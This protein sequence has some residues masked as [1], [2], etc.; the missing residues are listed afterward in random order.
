MGSTS[1][2]GVR[3]IHWSVEMS[4]KRSLRNI[5]RNT[6]VSP[7]LDVVAHGEGM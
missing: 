3:A 5:S 4:A 6:S 2:G 7:R 1:A